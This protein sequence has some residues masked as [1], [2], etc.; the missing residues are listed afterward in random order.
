MA[1]NCRKNA[2]TMG[3]DRPFLATMRWLT[4]TVST[5]SSGQAGFALKTLG[6]ISSDSYRGCLRAIASDA[7]IERNLGAPRERAVAAI[8]S[9]V[10]LLSGAIVIFQGSIYQA[11][12]PEPALAKKRDACEASS[13]LLQCI[14]A[15]GVPIADSQ[16]CRSD[17]SQLGSTD[18]HKMVQQELALL[19]F[20]FP[21]PK[22]GL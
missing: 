18:A 5:L 14:T 8:A 4:L 9:D 17:I 22:S 20:V 3:S 2:A 10:I 7:G 21:D 6:G 13:F 16:L 11:R 19:G 12:K 1:N 15:R